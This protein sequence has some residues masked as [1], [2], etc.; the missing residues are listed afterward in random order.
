MTIQSNIF[1]YIFGILSSID[2]QEWESHLIQNAELKADI[3]AL[4]KI[5]EEKSIASEEEYEK[6]LPQRKESSEIEEYIEKIERIIRRI[7]HREYIMSFLE[8]DEDIS[9]EEKAE[10][11]AELQQNETL[12]KKVAE[13]KEITELIKTAQN[14]EKAKAIWAYIQAQEKIEKETPVIPVWRKTWAIAASIFVLIGISIGVYFALQ[15]D[16]KVYDNQYFADTYLST[17]YS[18]T[19]KMGKADDFEQIIGLYGNQKYQEVITQITN[20]KFDNPK[21][22]MMLAMSYIQ[23]NQQELAINLLEKLVETN[24]EDYGNDARKYLAVIWILKGQ[25]AKAQTLLNDILKHQP[26]SSQKQEVDK[27]LYELKKKR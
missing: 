10:F 15:E 7:K 22:N 19:G 20:G 4:R 24:D 11:D 17:P 1:A 27:I 21:A 14:V 26:D 12:Q 16:T 6:L 2:K 3:R 8:P 18:I 25:N 5:L 13:I 9:L 23:T